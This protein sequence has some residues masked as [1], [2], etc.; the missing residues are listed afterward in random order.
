M[1]II[2]DEIYNSKLVKANDL[3]KILLARA[4]FRIKT[5]MLTLIIKKRKRSR[6]LS[7]IRISACKSRVETFII[8]VSPLELSLPF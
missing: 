4:L 8:L 5:R 1:R 7:F 2:T 6:H 3:K